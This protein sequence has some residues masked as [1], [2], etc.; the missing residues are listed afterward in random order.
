MNTG[1]LGKLG[2]IFLPGNL[3]L[4]GFGQLAWG[5]DC[6]ARIVWRQVEPDIWGEDTRRR[7]ILCGFLKAD[8]RHLAEQFRSMVDSMGTDWLQS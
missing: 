8:F 1:K 5:K 6:K 3:G 4:Q 2:L 7:I